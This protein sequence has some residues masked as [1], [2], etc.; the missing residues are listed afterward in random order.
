MT[1]SYVNYFYAC[2]R[3]VIFEQKATD[4]VHVFPSIGMENVEVIGGQDNP[5]NANEKHLQHRH[6]S[7]LQECPEPHLLQ[8]LI[9]FKTEFHFSSF[10]SE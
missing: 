3:V 8:V 5:E 2:S 1:L 10:L 7:H 9:H 4:L 6:R